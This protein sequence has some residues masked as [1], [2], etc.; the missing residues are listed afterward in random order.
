MKVLAGDLKRDPQ[1]ESLMRTR[2]HELGIR[3]GS[4]L[5]E[6][7]RAP[8]IAQAISVGLGRGF[9]ISR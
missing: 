4:R 7:M 8:T 1:L 5:D 2:S 9:G 6:M 3:L